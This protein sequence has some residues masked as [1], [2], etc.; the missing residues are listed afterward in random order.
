MFLGRRTDSFNNKNNFP[1]WM[2]LSKRHL[3]SNPTL[4][5]LRTLEF[6]R[7]NMVS[8]R[9]QTAKTQLC[10]TACNKITFS[11]VGQIIWPW[12]V[13]FFK[14][15]PPLFNP[16]I[17]S[18]WHDRSIWFHSICVHNIWLSA[19]SG[20][21]TPVLWGLSLREVLKAHAEVSQAVFECG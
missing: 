9:K 15:S 18:L 6:V 3:W 16:P 2:T 5:I 8:E 7:R 4:E 11:T 17:Q 14:T 21:N 19:G 1:L 13:I 20:Q 12:A 10:T